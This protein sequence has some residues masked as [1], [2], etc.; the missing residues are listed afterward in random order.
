LCLYEDLKFNKGKKN[1]YIVMEWG[2]RS[3]SKQWKGAH[4]VFFYPAIW[5]TCGLFVIL[6]GSISHLVRLEW[7]DI[8]LIP[9]FLIYLL[10]RDQGLRAGCLAFFMGILTDIIG[11]CQLGLFAFTYSCIILGIIRCRQF[12]DFNNIKTSILFVA[13]FL[14][15]KWAFLL[16]ALQ[17]FP[18]GQLIPS[19]SSTSVLVSILITSLMTPLLFYC[20]DLAGGSEDLGYTQKGTLAYL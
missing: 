6:R 2:S 8:D 16:G 3:F 18:T 9:V 10:A 12:L 19:I 14:F 20:L 5:L 1:Y 17:L 15:T 4:R 7:L 13:I 11:P